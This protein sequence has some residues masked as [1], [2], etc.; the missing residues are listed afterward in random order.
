MKKN[1]MTIVLAIML[2]ML[3]A[4]PVFAQ[5]TKESAAASAAPVKISLWY[6]AAITEAGP[7]PADWVA[8]QIIREKLNIDLELTALPSNESD[9]DVKIQAA[10]AAN[11]LP[12]VF[13]VR[14]D[15]WLRLVN[16][17][18]IAPV[19]SLYAKMPVRTAAQYDSASIA[20][21]TVSGK[22]YGFAS[23]GSISKNEG[24]LIRKDWLDKLGLAIPKTTEDL[25]KVLHAFTYNDP[26]GNGRNDTYGFG[27][28]LEINNYEGGLGRRLQPILGAFG[29][30]GTWNLTEANAGLSV[31]KP[32][33][34]DAMV[35]I[36]SLVDDGSIDPNWLAYQ[37]DDFRAAW[38]QGRFG[39]MREQNAAYAATANYAPFDKNFPDGEWI[40]IDPPVGPKGHSSVGPYTT[41]YRI[42][43]ISAKAAQAG[44]AEKIA[45]LLEWMS[46]D[47]G[48]YLLGWGVEGVNYVKDANGIPVDKDMPLGFSTATGQTVTQLRNMVFFNGDV[49]LY[50]RYPKYVTEV[51]KKEMSALDVLRDMESRK[52]TPN[53]GGDT[54]PAPNADLKRFYEQGLAEFLTGRRVLNQ[55]NWNA[56]IAEFDR[57]GGKAWEDA[58]I[59]HAKANNLLY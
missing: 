25:A 30:E 22:S 37:K 43:A 58:G 11:N 20:F 16:Q 1:V 51:S 36:K 42:Y 5:G 34:Y 44:K 59:A 8:L 31:R 39:V 23:P 9:Q 50:A 33:M 38:K 35:Y 10:G 29:V 7:P 6:G 56:W 55:Q 21:T 27:A 32:E 41:G 13:M 24:L 46:S 54:L 47:E 48:Y 26:D 49:E 53:N 15:A 14:R 52:W 4:L 17:G 19:D 3:C 45:E 12:D 28:F 18:L 2:A 57:V 40:V